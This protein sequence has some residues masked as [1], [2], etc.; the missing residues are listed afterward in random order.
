[1]VFRKI[2]KT[3]GLLRKLHNF[4]SRAALVT[5]YK[6]FIRPHLDYGRAVRSFFMVGELSKNVGNMV[7]H[8]KKF[9]KTLAKVP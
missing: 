3:I 1:M 5:I 4:L 9:K 7:G 8:D 2:S 6:S